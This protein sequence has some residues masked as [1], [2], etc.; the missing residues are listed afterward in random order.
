MSIRN[1]NI[2]IFPE[3]LCNVYK[4]TGCPKKIWIG[5]LYLNVH[6]HFLA[7][8]YKEDLGLLSEKFR[9]HS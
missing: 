8:C 7:R 3:K 5:V 1:N 6:V 4:L 9:M 2:Q